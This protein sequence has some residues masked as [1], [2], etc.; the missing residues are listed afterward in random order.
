MRLLSSAPRRWRQ[1]SSNVR[2]HIHTTMPVR[3][4]RMRRSAS[5]KVTRFGI[6][7]NSAVRIILAA[8]LRSLTNRSKPSCLSP[9]ASVQPPG[10]VGTRG[11]TQQASGK[12]VRY[13]DLALQARRK[14]PCNAASRVQRQLSTAP[15]TG[16]SALRLGQRPTLGSR[17]ACSAKRE[18]PVVPLALHHPRVF[19]R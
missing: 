5:S 19:P 15:A 8:S 12:Q 14:A 4:L 13:S 17:T 1:L 7:V 10:A 11:L 9:W 3:A 18:A 6:A 16:D 2:P